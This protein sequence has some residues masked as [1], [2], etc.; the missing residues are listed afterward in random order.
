MTFEFPT[1]DNHFQARF[2]PWI[3]LALVLAGLLIFLLS[4]RTILVDQVFSLRIFLGVLLAVVGLLYLKRP[5]FAIAPNRLTVYSFF[6]QVVKRYPFADFH[7]IEIDSGKVYIRA[8]DEAPEAENGNA[9]SF[10][11]RERVKIQRWMTKSSDWKSLKRL[12]QA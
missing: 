11:N 1:E 6:G 10:E 2:N 3:G 8:P 5:Y 4:L 12:A 9:H 7:S